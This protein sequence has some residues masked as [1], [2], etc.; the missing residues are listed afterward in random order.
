MGI[1]LNTH[2]YTWACA[3]STMEQLHCGSEIRKSVWYNSWFPPSIWHLGSTCQKNRKEKI[4]YFFLPRVEQR[5]WCVGPWETARRVC[6]LYSVVRRPGLAA[7]S[8][9]SCLHRGQSRPSMP[10]YSGHGDGT[11]P[12]PCLSSALMEAADRAGRSNCTHE[13]VSVGG[14]TS[15]ISLLDLTMGTMWLIW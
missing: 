3:W 14:L 8:H 11:R 15:Q 12:S 9:S 2:E 13:G 10:L 6:L 4:L 1:Q 7:L 5:L